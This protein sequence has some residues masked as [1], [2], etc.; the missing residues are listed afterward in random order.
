M[1][2]Y[3]EQVEGVESSDPNRT[4]PPDKN[5]YLLLKQMHSHPLPLLPT[6]SPVSLPEGINPAYYVEQAIYPKHFRKKSVDVSQE[7][8]NTDS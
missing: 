3:S 7:P 8:Q 6:G 2:K 1:G 4:I 5:T